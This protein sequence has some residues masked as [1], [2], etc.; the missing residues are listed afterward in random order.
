M[1]EVQTPPCLPTCLFVLFPGFNLNT[2]KKI[3][4]KNPPILI[5]LKKTPFT[6]VSKLST[7]IQ[8]RCSSGLDSRTAG[9]KALIHQTMVHGF[10][11]LDDGSRM[12]IPAGI[13]RS[14]AEESQTTKFASKCAGCSAPRLEA[15]KLHTVISIS[16]MQL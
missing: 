2:T 12:K 11:I 6:F 1:S 4:N 14:R 8:L 10:L 7:L 9:R 13:L 16:T 5:N 15:I 3:Y